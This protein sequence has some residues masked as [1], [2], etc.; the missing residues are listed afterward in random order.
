MSFSLVGTAWNLAG[1]AKHIADVDTSW[2]NSVT[3]HHTGSPDLSMRRGGGLVVQH[4]RNIQDYYKQ[5]KGWDRGP[6]L[7]IDDVDI[8]GMSPLS[9][10]GIHA[11]SFNADSVGIEVL[12]NYDT[13]DPRSGRGLECWALAAQVT[14][15]LL[16]K[17]G[18]P[19]N[20]TTVKFHRDDPLTNKS[21]PGDKVSKP[22]FIT[23]VQEELNGAPAKEK[24]PERSLR[25][26]AIDWQV[27]S[28]LKEN[29][30][31]N[32]DRLGELS[33]RLENIVWQAEKIEEGGKI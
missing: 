11:K 3:L 4:I 19:A 7:F 18:L 27:L 32:S 10:R 33:Q 15:T 2:A 9:E 26:L 31:L 21:C 28:I 14:A 30:D 16:G 6:H 8:N 24:P 17:L 5:K 23:M 20:P 22:W 1:F 25:L 29:D 13:E 12:G